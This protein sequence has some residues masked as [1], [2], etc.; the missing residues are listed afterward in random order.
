MAGEQPE[1]SGRPWSRSPARGD[2]VRGWEGRGKRVEWARGGERENELR[3][4]VY[5]ARGGGGKKWWVEG[6]RRPRRWWRAAT[7]LRWWVW[8][9]GGG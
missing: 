7:G 2:L 5:W 4:G 8:E 1:G 6:Q 3:L 9:V